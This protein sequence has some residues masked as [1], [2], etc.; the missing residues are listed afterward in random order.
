MKAVL[1]VEC[2]KATVTWCN[3]DVVAPVMS[4]VP[5]AVRD[6]DLQSRHD[7]VAAVGEHAVD[8]HEGHQV[9]PLVDVQGSILRSQIHVELSMI[10]QVSESRDWCSLRISIH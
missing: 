1:H 5:L 3:V 2:D 9:V 8:K 10:T 6:A 4:A 7:G